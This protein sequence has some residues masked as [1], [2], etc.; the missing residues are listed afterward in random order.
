MESAN[1]APLR[2]KD[3]YVIE[4]SIQDFFLQS[5]WAHG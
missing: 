4:A 2:K 3:R 5:M 1:C